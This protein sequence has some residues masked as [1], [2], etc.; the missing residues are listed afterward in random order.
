MCHCVKAEQCM[1]NCNKYTFIFQVVYISFL[2]SQDFF[3]H[4]NCR[5]FR[6]I[7]SLTFSNT[8][9]CSWLGHRI[10]LRIVKLAQQSSSSLLHQ[11]EEEYKTNTND[12]QNILGFAFEPAS[13]TRCTF[14]HSLSSMSG[15]EHWVVTET[16]SWFN[17]LV[18]SDSG[19]RQLCNAMASDNEISR[20]RSFGEGLLS[21]RFGWFGKDP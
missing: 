21:T 9:Y 20:N 2:F 10:M 14:A 16:W 8:K 11:D 18:V 19:M 4:E 17:S 1:C 13:C 12:W 6:C 7:K 15:E 3:G 5:N